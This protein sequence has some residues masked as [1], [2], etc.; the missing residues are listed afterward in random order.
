MIELIYCTDC[1][2]RMYVKIIKI[3]KTHFSFSSPVFLNPLFAFFSILS[4]PFLFIHSPVCGFHF[5]SLQDLEDEGDM[6]QDLQTRRQQRKEEVL[7]HYA[8]AAS[9]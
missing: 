4:L 8:M 2:Y 5:Q 3:C 6:L 1:T 7:V 9:P